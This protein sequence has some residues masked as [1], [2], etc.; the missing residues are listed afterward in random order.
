MLTCG[1]CGYTSSS[2]ANLKRHQSKVHAVQRFPCEAEGCTVTCF[3]A[4]DLA[5]HALKH[6]DACL[7]CPVDSC[8]YTCKLAP[9]L[10]SHVKRVHSGTCKEVKRAGALLLACSLSTCTYQ[11]PYPRLLRLHQA[12]MHDASRDYILA[13]P[14]DG[15]TFAPVDH[16]ELLIH[17]RRHGGLQ[18]AALAAAAH[19]SKAQLPR[20]AEV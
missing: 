15:C 7:P 17:V 14:L 19:T 3:S 11:T 1:S 10:N 8:T 18:R 13:C 6:G 20:M 5:R 4:S 12:R 16:R 2:P 9:T